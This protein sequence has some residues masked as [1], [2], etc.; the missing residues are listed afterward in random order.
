[1]EDED[2]KSVKSVLDILEGKREYSALN[3]SA[4]DKYDKDG[5]ESVKSGLSFFCNPKE[6]G[7]LDEHALK[8][9]LQMNDLEI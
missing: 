2:G 1:M 6:K 4:F 7:E 5:A 3:Q 9:A 8:L